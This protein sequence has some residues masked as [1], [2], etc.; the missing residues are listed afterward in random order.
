MAEDR[1][2]PDKLNYRNPTIHQ[3]TVYFRQNHSATIAGRRKLLANLDS[4]RWSSRQLLTKLFLLSWKHQPI[5]IFHSLERRLS[6]FQNLL[7]FDIWHTSN[8]LHWFDVN[9]SRASYE[10]FTSSLLKTSSKYSLFAFFPR[11]LY[12]RAWSLPPTFQNA[13]FVAAYR[14]PTT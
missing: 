11:V 4:L 7:V 3:P 2:E 13:R 10:L 9:G 6:V 12:A 1:N 14:I 5:S 8:A